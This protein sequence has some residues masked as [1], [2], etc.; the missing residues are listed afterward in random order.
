MAAYSIVGN[1]NLIREIQNV[2]TKHCGIAPRKISIKH[3]GTNTD[4]IVYFRYSKI[5][6]IK[7]IEKWMYQDATIFLKRKKD[8]FGE[9]HDLGIRRHN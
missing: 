9:I 7:L 1:I 3:P 6:D 4:N 2:I 8:K 5:D